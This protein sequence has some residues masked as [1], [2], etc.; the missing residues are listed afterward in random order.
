MHKYC[1]LFYLFF[2]TV[3]ADAAVHRVGTYNIRY[4][5]EAD[6]AEKA[7]TA[8]RP[9]VVK[10]LRDTMNYDVVAL[11]EV[12]NSGYWN[13]LKENMPAYTFHMGDTY[14]VAVAYRT[15][16]YKCLDKGYFKLVPSPKPSG[17]QALQTR[18]AVWVKLQDKTTG[19]V[20][21]F[22]ATHL[23]LYPISIREGARVCAEKM[24]QIAG[25]DACIITGDLNCEPMDRDPHANFAQYFGDAREMCKTT[26]KGSYFTFASGMNPSASTKKRIDFLYVRNVDVESYWANPSTLGRTLMPSDHVPVVCEVTILPKMRQTTHVVRNVEEL[27]EAARRV[28]VDDIIHLNAGRY[29]LGDSTLVVANT[30]VIEGDDEV[31]LTGA[32]QLIKGHP[33]ISLEIRNIRIQDATCDKGG[34]GS[35]M[36]M[37]GNY[38]KLTDCVV[39]GCRT[40]GEGLIYAQDCRLTVDGC[41]FSN[42][43]S[44]YRSSGLVMANDPSYQ[45]GYTFPLTLTNSTFD[46]N[47]AYHGSAVY[48]LSTYSAYIANNSFVGNRADERGCI[49]I[50]APSNTSD[51]RL[52]NNTFIN[53]TIRVSSTRADANVGGSSIWQNMAST[54]CL[55]MVNNTIVGNYTGCWWGE[56]ESSAK[57]QSGTVQSSSGQLRLYNNIIAGNFSSCPGRGDVSMSNPASALQGSNNVF[58]SLTNT[59]YPIARSDMAASDYATSLES[60]VTLLGGTTAEGVYHPQVERYGERN[61]VALSPKTTMYAGQNIAVVNESARSAATIGS[62]I[63]NTG[64]TTGTLTQDQIGTMRNANSVPGAME[65]GRIPSENVNVNVNVN[66]NDGQKVMMNNQIYIYHEEKLYT[67]FG[68]PVRM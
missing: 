5:A 31:E 66:V 12:Y 10:M 43:Q 40:N 46:G 1:I 41:M 65:A 45:S 62:D 3:A 22:T 30:C 17:W 53:N 67:V 14:G 37:T 20:L 39:D 55:T 54:G 34:Y 32:T 26:P 25:N 21:V 4:P 49:F 59:N 48:N 42:N 36:Y 28:Q 23:D 19:D 15:S 38:L 50:D 60:L 63:L 52:V 44:T 13:Y 56:G 47:A 8:R 29:D 58:S 33:F 7:W 16:K 11:E 9:Y 61:M 27:Y 6:T 18:W 2:F 57:F 24:R 68:M 64:S 51:I 35:I